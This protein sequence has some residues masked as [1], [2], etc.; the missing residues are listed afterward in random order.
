MDPATNSGEYLSRSDP[1]VDRWLRRQKGPM[2]SSRSN[3]ALPEDWRA[4]I[5]DVLERARAAA[6]PPADND[7][8]PKAEAGQARVRTGY[9][10]G[11]R[12]AS[13]GQYAAHA[14]RIDAI[15]HPAERAEPWSL[16]LTRAA[17]AIS[18]W[19][20]DARMHGALDL[21]ATFKDLPDPMPASVRPVRAVAAWLTHN[22]GEGLVPVTARLCGI[23]LADLERY[24]RALRPA[25]Y[26]VHGLRLLA[27]LE[28]RR[29]AAPARGR[30]DKDSTAHA[31]L[32]KAAV[33][34]IHDAHLMTKAD[35][36]KAAGIS[37]PT[38]NTWLDEN[39]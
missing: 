13:A 33:R 36:A 35:L 37:R 12:T 28:T 8:W 23:V 19:D 22:S 25:W 39:A 3:A 31:E 7:A 15:E 2:M 18:S 30:P 6:A 5:L 10:A 11:R 26:A 14:L 34:G 1:A 21:R 17:P 32:L 9:E 24:E 20:W 29:P 16:A 4:P 38:L 27:E